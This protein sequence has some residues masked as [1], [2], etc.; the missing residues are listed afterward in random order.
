M[1]RQSMVRMGKAKCQSPHRASSFQSTDHSGRWDRSTLE[2]Q[3]R[4]ARRSVVS[5]LTP[6]LF[7]YTAAVLPHHKA[8]LSLPLSFELPR[9]LPSSAGEADRQIGR[10]ELAAERKRR[11]LW[12]VCVWSALFACCVILA[13]LSSVS[14]YCS[15]S[16]SV[17]G[18]L[19]KGLAEAARGYDSVVARPVFLPPWCTARYLLRDCRCL[20][21]TVRS[22]CEAG[23]G[24]GLRQLS[25][26]SAA[27]F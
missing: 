14:R 24:E 11:N 21:A 6:Q 5:S 10:K 19:R 15:S 7:S 23:E 8:P 4:C 26:P 20:S 17:N 1:V 27:V 9:S 13:P 12:R 16:S 22:T 25:T 18:A 3:R 2:A